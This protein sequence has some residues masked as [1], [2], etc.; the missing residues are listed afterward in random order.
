MM[1]KIYIDYLFEKHL[2]VSEGEESKNPLETL[3]AL[4]NLF[5]IR[6]VKGDKL[7]RDYMIRVA[8][9]S[10]GENVPEPFYRGF[11]QSVRQLTSD[12]L[13][14]DQM[15]HYITTYG[16]G[17]FSEAGHSLFE[18]QFERTA[19][20][21]GA[22]IKEFTIVTKEEAEAILSESVNNLLAG[23]RPLSDE[24]YELVKTYIIDYGFNAED[25]ASKNTCVRLL[26][27]THIL[28]IADYMVLSDVIRLVDEI[29]Y[30]E[31]ANTNL[32]KLN[33]K[34]QTRKFITQV[35]NRM[36]ETGRV[37]IR[38]CFEKKKLWNGLLHHI[39][40]KAVSEEAQKF[41]DAMRGKVNDSVYS[42]F[43]RHMTAK[44]IRAAIDTLKSGKGSAAV[45]RKLN[46]MI[47]RCG[48][49][50]DM[51][52]IC[53]NID[54]KNVIV[55]IQLLVEYSMRNGGSAPRRFAF[56]KY[57]MLKVHNET[58]EEQKKRKSMISEGQA[59]MLADYI[60]ENLKKVLKGRLGRVYI[61]PAMKN[62]A[63]PIQ[64]NTSQGGFGVLTRGSRVKLP[65]TKK[66]RA[67][68]YWEKVN[69]IDLSVFGIND[70]GER[71]EFSWRTMAGNQ[72]QAITYSGDETSGYNGGSEYFDID[73]DEFR[74]MY[75]DLQYIILCDNVYSGTSFANCICKAGYMTRDLNDSGEV[76]EPKTVKTSFVI[77][78]NSTFAYLYGIDLRTNELI[79]LN[80]ARNSNAAVAGTTDMSF[81]TDYFHVTD[82][83]NVYTFFEMMATELVT[84]ISEAEVVVT[85]KAVE[86]GEN[87]QVIREYDTDKM[88]AIMNK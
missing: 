69:D 66:L 32:K 14:F 38:N 19:F 25:I 17:N 55:L 8:A 57:N 23:T 77:D 43:E 78:C 12:Q 15:I 74:R 59:A 70:K 34:N 52:Y 31:Y 67:F 37:D 1:K 85:D 49:L 40:Y 4:A 29:N 65:E 50:E 36:F 16:L 11:P 45:I 73:M 82:I 41:V 88:I 33:L 26:M 83:I 28:A 62:Y 21:E 10:L 46:Y 81:L 7:V 5:N 18:E 56:T 54:T 2:M 9:D 20:K 53:S 35:I 63:L 3:F 47:S 71:R 44:N 51:Q 42:E 13:L 61:D 80:M 27:D 39:H 64:E 87:V 48:S 58:P 60:S 79:W 72:S 22:D 76:Y 6:I 24:Q 68:T 84:D 30:R 86:C 75:P